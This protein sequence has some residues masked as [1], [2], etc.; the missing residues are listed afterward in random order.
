MSMTGLDVFDKT[1]QAT[2]SWLKD[3]MFELNWSDRH[4]AYLALKGCFH[5]LRDRLTVEEA[6]QVGAQLP[7]LLRGLY[8]EGWNPAGKPVKM[9]G[10]KDF[11]SRV[12]EYFPNEPDLD[13]ETVVRAVFKLLHFR[14]SEGEINNIKGILPPYLKSL[15]PRKM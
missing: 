3:I 2:N 9:R 1:L 11:Y 4:R 10:K 13:P 5:A 14:I 15:W 8:Y 12:R 7:M 6:V